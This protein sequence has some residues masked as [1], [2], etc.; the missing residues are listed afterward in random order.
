MR[1]ANRL[2]RHVRPL[3]A[4]VFYYS[5]LVPLARWYVRLRRQ[6]LI[7]LTYHRAAGGNLRRHFL[8]LR[9]HYRVLPLE[10]ALEEL[11]APSNGR[12]GFRDRRTPL[13]ITFDDGYRDNYTHAYALAN[14][15]AVPI[16]IFLLPGYVAD[17]HRFHWLEGNYL[18]NHA[19]DNLRLR[20][21][22]PARAR[23]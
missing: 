18:A 13:V 4:A 1:G 22:K 21:K 15:L 3:I 6:H 11:Y 7:I 16:T 20:L 12:P 23:S 2:Y 10:T 9:R 14:E 8:Y 5:G 19:A 17:G